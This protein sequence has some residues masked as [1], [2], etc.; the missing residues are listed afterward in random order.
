VRKPIVQLIRFADRIPFDLQQFRT[1]VIDTTNI[2]TLV[3]R[4]DTYRTEI[5]SQIRVALESP[6]EAGN[7]LTAFFPGF[8]GALPR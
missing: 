5:A 4:L 7:P 3:P 6:A 2:Y 8:W 1:I